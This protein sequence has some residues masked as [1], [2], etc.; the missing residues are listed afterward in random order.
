MEKWL[1]DN[2]LSDTTVLPMLKFEKD[3]E[4]LENDFR[5]LTKEIENISEKNKKISKNNQY[6]AI[7]ANRYSRRYRV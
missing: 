6:R 1:T 5:S 7:E 4:E 2:K 3:T